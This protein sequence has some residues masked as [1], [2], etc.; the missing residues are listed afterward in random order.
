MPTKKAIKK[1]KKKTQE[2]K[3]EQKKTS[4]GD[5]HPSSE[6]YE[7]LGEFEVYSDE[8]RIAKIFGVKERGARK[9]FIRIMTRSKTPYGWRVNRGV[10][11]YNYLN[12]NRLIEGIGKI[13]KKLKWK[14]VQKDNIEKLKIKLREKED[15]IVNLEQLNEEARQQHEGIMELLKKEQRKVLKS[16]TRNFKGD[17]ARLEK[18]IKEA[19]NEKISESELQEF[20]YEHPWFFGTEYINAEPQKMRGVHNKFDFYL[21][22]FNKTNDIIEIK[23]LSDPI[24]KKDGSISAKVIQA[25]DQLM[26]YMEGTIAAAHSRKISEEE[27]IY[28]LR[29]RGIVIIGKDSSKEANE[30]LHMWNYQLA[31]IAIL[32]YGDL[33]KKAQSLL[34]HIKEEKN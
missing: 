7:E 2:T 32:T 3:A 31:H 25:V 26:K 11:L 24:L 33:V 15:I 29:P 27:G 13:V 30:K 5:F 34:K 8:K 10:N 12:V 22:R 1:N 6:Y 21:E 28:E 20:L 16:K 4:L 17:I 14:I 9:R 19:E 18:L 23:L